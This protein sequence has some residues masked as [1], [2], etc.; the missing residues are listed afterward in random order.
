MELIIRKANTEDVE[1][2][3]ALRQQQLQEEGATP[4]PDISGSVG[5]YFTGAIADGSFVCFVAVDAGEIVATGGCA[6]YRLP[7][8]YGNPTGWV[9]HVA[10]MH[11]LSPYRR[12]GVA[13]EI[14]RLIFEEA[15][16]RGISDV[17]VNASK[18][19]AYLY[20]SCGFAEKGNLFQK[21]L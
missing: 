20:R 3:T 19:G 2:L 7:P 8:H 11:T 5:D 17:R 1:R 16:S 13:S 10:D 14:L 4:I 6:F 15:K 12:R 18:V 21:F 9:A